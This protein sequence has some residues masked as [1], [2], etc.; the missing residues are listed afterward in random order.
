[1]P[2]PRS[3]KQPL[4]SAVERLLRITVSRPQHGQRDCAD[5]AAIGCRIDIIFDVG[6]NVGQ[7][8]THFR[9]SFPKS[10]I[11]CF[12]PVKST[13][14][15]L[16]LSLV[17]DP[18]VICHNVALSDA[19][20]ET[21]IYI[22]DNSTMSSL[23]AP[24]Q[25]TRAETVKLSTV[26]AYASKAGVDRIDILKIDAEG[27]DLKVL[28]GAGGLLSNGRIAFVLAEVGFMPGDDR[29]VL[30]DEVR[31]LLRP[32][33][34]HPYG[35]YGQTLE[36]SGERRLRYANALFCNEQAFRE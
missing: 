3:L 24:E 1:M 22:T 6:A 21:T 23:K 26:D 20:G 18:Q 9:E 36:W 19:L 33:G 5:I 7:T 27:H 35:F 10:T 13:F 8:A 11:H 28:K 34:H 32:Y 30:F 14:E 4:Q 12:E 29:H 31:E 15:T 16:T 17:R 2:L 25:Y